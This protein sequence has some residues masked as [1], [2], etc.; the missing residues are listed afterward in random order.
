[1]RP[2]SQ[3]SDKG[4][5]DKRIIYSPIDIQQVYMVR[6]HNMRLYDPN[7]THGKPH[8]IWK[9]GD[10]MK[11]EGS[12]SS[13]TTVTARR[14]AIVECAAKCEFG[15]A[16]FGPA[17]FRKEFMITVERVQKVRAYL[18]RLLPQADR[19]SGHGQRIEA[20]DTGSG[21]QTT[22]RN[23]TQSQCSGWNSRQR[24]ADRGR[25]LAAAANSIADRIRQT[26]AADRSSGHRQRTETADRAADTTIGKR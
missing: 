9:M 15:S 11:K 22:D 21:R 16:E 17:E 4:E 19:C 23:S 13:S 14:K 18:L 12:W 2:G 7:K 20:P 24:Q 5:T 1:M 26:V 25:P 3:V 8:Y 10:D 6:M